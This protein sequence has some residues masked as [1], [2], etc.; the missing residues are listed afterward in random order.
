MIDRNEHYQEIFHSL[1]AI[2]WDVAHMSCKS[3][4]FRCNKMATVGDEAK[5]IISAY[6]DAKVDMITALI[7]SDS[8]RRYPLPKEE[9]TISANNAQPSAMDRLID[10]AV[11][12]VLAESESASEQISDEDT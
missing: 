6:I 2:L 3:L 8:F 9:V 7:S 1:D 10:I 4:E 11:A 5:K 12:K